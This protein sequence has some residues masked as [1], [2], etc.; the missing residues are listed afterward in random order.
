MEH[1]SFISLMKEVNIRKI[2]IGELKVF[3]LLSWVRG[4]GGASLIS[5]KSIQQAYGNQPLQIIGRLIFICRKVHFEA[6][7]RPTVEI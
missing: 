3:F 7:L 1:F 2:I 4:D 6:A 5:R